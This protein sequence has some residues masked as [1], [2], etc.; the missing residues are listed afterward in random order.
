MFLEFEIEAEPRSYQ[1]MVLVTVTDSDGKSSTSVYMDGLTQS[2]ARQVQALGRFGFEAGHT[3][4][5]LEQ[6]LAAV[7]ELKELKQQM[8][9]YS[10]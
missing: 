10:S 8:E 9:Q 2:Q 4:G 7:E 5:K 6:A 1:Y 3:Q